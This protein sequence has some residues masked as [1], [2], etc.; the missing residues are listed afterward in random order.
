MWLH[1]FVGGAVARQAPDAEQL[2]GWHREAEE[3]PVAAGQYIKLY[4]EKM[5]LWG[6]YLMAQFL[7][8]GAFEL[9][10][11]NTMQM[12]S[13]GI[14]NGNAWSVP[15]LEAL[16]L[17]AGQG[18]L[19]EVGCGNGLWASLL[20]DSLAADVLAFD[21]ADW[22]ARY[23]EREGDGSMMGSR[24]AAVRQGGPE[25]VQA[26]PDRTLMLM[27]PDYSGRGAFGTT[28]LEHYTGDMLVLVGE[29]RGSTYG[30]VNPWGQSFSE[31]LINSVERDFEVQ[32]RLPLPCWPLAADAVM[33]WR[34]R[35]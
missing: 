13:V 35:H 23:G 21:T 8:G 11:M 14:R 25:Q 15:T 31:E 24:S 10:A 18:P 33:L 26:H 19:L 16:R 34:R 27:W 2:A 12:E 3:G 30:T 1:N 6:R 17:I 5:A 9:S 20:R 28:C 4:F 32:T 22:D 29:W 7:C